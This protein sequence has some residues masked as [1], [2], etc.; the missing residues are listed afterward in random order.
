MGDLTAGDISAI[1]TVNNDEILA[2]CLARSPD[3]ASGRLGLRVI[4]GATSMAAAYNEGLDT[5]SGQIAL[6]VHQDVY[7][8]AGWLDRAITTLN[9]LTRNYPE[10]MVAGP[11]G[12]RETGAHIGRV[13]D[14][15]LRRELGESGFAPTPV[16]S[17]DELMLILRREPEFRFDTNLPHFH[18]YGT[19]LVQSARSMGRGAYAVELPLVHNNR[20]WDSLGGGYL[21]AYRYIR[22]KWRANLP[23]HT[24]VCRITHNPLPLWR[25]RWRRRHVVSRGEGLLADSVEVARAAGYERP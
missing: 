21:L 1:A 20:P 7:L 4:R 5:T 24:T 3:I 14:V 6:L 8:P 22:S 13:W 9:D 11:Y 19:D 25:A 23:I 18:M 17:L 16:G 2:Q 15:N 10:W 12:V